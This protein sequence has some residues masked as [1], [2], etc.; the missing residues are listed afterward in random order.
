METKQNLAAFLATYP[1]EQ[2]GEATAGYLPLSIDSRTIA[3][4]DMFVAI[5]GETHDGHDYAAAA[6]EK[7]A[8][9]IIVRNSW[10]KEKP[11]EGGTAIAVD[12]TLDFLQKL[13]AW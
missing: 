4:G 7:G 5:E 9:A 8:S 6:L 12:D 3:A 10:I 1:H 11:L 13:S 2:I